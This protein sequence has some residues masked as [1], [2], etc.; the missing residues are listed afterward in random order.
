MNTERPR[1]VVLTGAV[2]N[3]GDPP[4]GRVGPRSVELVF[5]ELQ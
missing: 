3:Q 1:W 2:S 4:R 5:R